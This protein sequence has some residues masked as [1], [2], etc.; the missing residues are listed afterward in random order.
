MKTFKILIAVFAISIGIAN[1]QLTNA[2]IQVSGLTCS[3][4]SKATEKSL[5]TLSFISDIKTDLNNNLYVITF[6][7]DVPVNLQAIS[8]K[9]Q[10]AGFSVNNLKV[11][12]NMDKVKVDNNQFSYGDNIY[13]LI[14]TPAGSLNGEVT[15]TVVDKGFVSPI[16]FKKYVAQYPDLNKPGA[17][18]LAILVCL[19]SLW[20]NCY[21]FYSCP[22]WG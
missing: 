2:Q 11:A 7:K 10:G 1:A 22:W 14:K 12:F 13:Q 4:C 9:V 3:M 16:A 5:R 17:Y 18:H 19:H 15:F 21:C 8:K 6:K 20:R